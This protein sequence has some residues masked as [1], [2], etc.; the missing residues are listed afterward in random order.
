MTAHCLWSCAEYILG[1]ARRY[2]DQ[3]RLRFGDEVEDMHV[4]S[5]VSFPDE[6]GEYPVSSA[7]LVAMQEKGG[8]ASTPGPNAAADTKKPHPEANRVDG[9]AQNWTGD[10]Q[11]MSDVQVAFLRGKFAI[12]TLI[13]PATED[14]LLEATNKLKGPTMTMQQI[15]QWWKNERLC[16]TR[17]AAARSDPM[18]DVQL[19]ALEELF[20]Q[21]RSLKEHKKDAIVQTLNKDAGPKVTYDM[22][23]IWWNDEQSRRNKLKKRKASGLAESTHKRQRKSP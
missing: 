4:D 15:R 18:S 11:K 23:R 7:V 6:L 16:R 13:D 9:R 17:Q 1:L 12:K 14:G 5:P 8:F 19:K 3:G 21:N 10:T 20:E 2:V 22:V